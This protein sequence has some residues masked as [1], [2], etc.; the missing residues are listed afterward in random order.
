MAMACEY[1]STHETCTLHASKKMFMLYGFVC[2]Y[3]STKAIT[4]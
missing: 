4:L 1:A 3:D 2:M